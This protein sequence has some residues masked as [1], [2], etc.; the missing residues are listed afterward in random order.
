MPANRLQ[1]LDAL[2]PSEV[3]FLLRTRDRRVLATIAY[4]DKAAQRLVSHGFLH[5]ADE[6]DPAYVRMFASRKG[7]RII[8]L[9]DEE[10]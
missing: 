3:A 10:R 7:E 5:I 8:D 6:P 2:R 1:L 9:L 4:G